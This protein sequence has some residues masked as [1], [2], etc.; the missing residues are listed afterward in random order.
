[1]SRTIIRAINLLV[2]SFSLFLVSLLFSSLATSPSFALSPIESADLSPDITVTLDGQTVDDEDVAADNLLSPGIVKAPLVGIPETADLS[3]YHFRQIGVDLHFMLSFDSTV[4]LPG[5]IVA[6]PADVIRLEG[7]TYTLEFD[8]AAQSIPAG[9]NVDA[10]AMTYGGDFILSFDTSVFLD[11]NVYF[12][13]DLTRFDGAS[14]SPFFSGAAAGLDAALD[15]DGAHLLISSG[16]LALSFD[17][18]GRVGGIDFDDEDVLE[19]DPS[20]GSWEMAWDTSVERTEWVPGAD[21]DAV[22]FVPE[23]TRFA[24]LVAGLTLLAIFNRGRRRR[25]PR[26]RGSRL[27]ARIVSIAL[28]IMLVSA[29]PA[30]AGDGIIEIDAIRAAVGSINGDPVADAPGFPV[31]ITEPGSYRL[32]TNLAVE[33]NKSGIHILA[34]DVTLNLAGFTIFG[35]TVCGGQPVVCTGPTAGS[36]VLVEAQNASIRGGTIAGIGAD[37][38]AHTEGAPENIGIMLRDLLLLSNSDR[39]ADLRTELAHSVGVRAILNGNDGMAI[40]P[41][42]VTLDGKAEGNG[43]DGVH[44]VV[45]GSVVVSGLHTRGNTLSGLRREAGGSVLRGIESASNGDDGISVRSSSIIS[46]SVASQNKEGIVIVDGTSLIAESVGVESILS[47]MLARNG[48]LALRNAMFDGDPFVTGLHCEIGVC[49]T[50]GNRIE[51]GVGLG[52]SATSILVECD[53]TGA[54]VTCP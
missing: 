25:S 33:A 38:I 30:V 36:G 1:M 10:L 35:T 19:Y 9:V 34:N 6:R 47:D 23:P 4:T 17:T 51:G 7:A 20:L 43:G 16:N 31:T 14:F 46:R 26:V 5:G 13:E 3:A 22:N 18:S 44:M 41:V 2:S 40:S 12:D 52:A 8:S 45:G 42:S 53:H 27:Q 11:G 39:G 24:Q 54:G 37:G 21:V 48:T 29:E 28:A 49:A 32:T 50:G 15:V